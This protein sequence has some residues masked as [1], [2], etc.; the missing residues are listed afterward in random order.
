M[1]CLSP[2]RAK[3]RPYSVRSAMTRQLNIILVPHTHWD[4][5]WYQTFQQFRIRLVRAVDTLL[6][7]LERDPGFTHF[8]LDGQTI[9]LDDYLEVEP[10]QEERLRQH[11]RAGRVLVG[12]WY[13]QLDEFLVSVEA[14][15]RN[16]Q[17]GLRRAADCG[18]AMRV[19]YLPDTFGHIAQM[20]QILRGF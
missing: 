19:G 16:L 3:D 4:R 14:R 6:D 18:E 13:L 7:I 10:E 5:E 17:F 12:L 9:V 2:S 8:M 15:V 11:I 20:P 1:V